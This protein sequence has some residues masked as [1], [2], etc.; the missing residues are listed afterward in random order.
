MNYRS[1]FSFIFAVSAAATASGQT[2]VEGPQ[3]KLI[4]KRLQQSGAQSSVEKID[5]VRTR[6][7]EVNYL[8]CSSMPDSFMSDHCSYRDEKAGSA[9]R[10]VLPGDARRLFQSLKDVVHV[11]EYGDGSGGGE[12][13]LNSI[14]CETPVYFYVY[15]GATVCTIHE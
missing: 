6:V 1:I 7:L 11:R 4:K 14:R 15:R 13:Q 10:N 2:D 8:N 9:Q 5:G 3:A 12:I